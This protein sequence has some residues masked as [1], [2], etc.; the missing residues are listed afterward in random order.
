MVYSVIGSGGILAAGSS[1]FSARIRTNDALWQF[2][3]K[4]LRIA[5]P[6]FQLRSPWWEPRD[7]GF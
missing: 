4:G 7:F 2:L 5:D 6:R 3:P 1:S